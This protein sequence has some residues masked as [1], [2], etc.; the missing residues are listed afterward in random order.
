MQEVSER[1]I[2]SKIRQ[3]LE[4][5]TPPQQGIIVIIWDIEKLEDNEQFKI[6][7]ISYEEKINDKNEKEFLRPLLVNRPNG[8]IRDYQNTIAFVYAD[9]Y[10]IDSLTD[11]ARMVCAIDDAQR[12]ERIR[13]DNDN[14]ITIRRKLTE[15]GGNLISECLNVNMIVCLSISSAAYILPMPYRSSSNYSLSIF[16]IFTYEIVS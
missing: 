3:T 5:L 12:D 15:A 2:N 1:K 7:I 13:S 16:F 8:E 10:G 9:E 14:L 11:S 4:S 6:F